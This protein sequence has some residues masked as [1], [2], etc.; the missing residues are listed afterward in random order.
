MIEKRHEVQILLKSEGCAQGLSI[1]CST[2]EALAWDPEWAD[3]HE[4]SG[5]AMQAVH[6]AG[7]TFTYQ[8]RQPSGGDPGPAGPA[9]AAAPAERPIANGK[10]VPQ[11]SPLPACS[12]LDV[13]KGVAQAA[14]ANGIHVA[15]G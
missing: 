2:P 9:A 14:K 5:R 10:I 15:A 13:P 8:K 12:R 7:S 3:T 1:A 11:T 6:A 4:I